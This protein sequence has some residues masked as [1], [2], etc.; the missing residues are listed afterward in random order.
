LIKPT[1]ILVPADGTPKLLAFGIAKLLDAGGAATD[2]LT[3]AGAVMMT[4]ENATPEQVLNMP[5][6]TAT[7]IYA[8]GLLLYRL[9]TGQPAYRVGN[10]PND[11]AQAICEHVP[12]RPSTA[13]RRH[14]VE[15][16]PGEMKPEL[17]WRYR[18]TTREKLSRHLK[19]DLDN[20]VLLALR[21][22]PQR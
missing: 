12:E 7:D 1:N 16:A 19:G 5:V 2:G 3:R 8:L 22:E 14:S 17:I 13:V 4:P 6:T 10:S 9:L 11:M 20:I 18:G 15:A 21:K